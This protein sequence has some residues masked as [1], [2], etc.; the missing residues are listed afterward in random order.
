LN[1]KAFKHDIRNNRPTLKNH[2]QKIKG[3]NMEKFFCLSSDGLIYFLGQFNDWEDAELFA[4]ERKIDCIWL[5]GE[6]SANSWK[7]TLTENLSLK[8]LK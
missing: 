8:G 4:T 5:C 1:P 2:S 7:D 6:T 3:V